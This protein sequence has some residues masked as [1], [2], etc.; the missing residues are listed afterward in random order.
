MTLVE[1][2]VNHLK[3]NKGVQDVTAARY[4]H[5]LLITAKFIH[6]EEGRRDY[7]TGGKRVRSSLTQESVG[8]DTTH[9]KESIICDQTFLATVSRACSKPSLQVRRK[10]RCRQSASAYEFH[11][12]ASVCCE[13]WPSQRTQNSS[14]AKGRS[15]RET[16]SKRLVRLLPQGDNV[17]AFSSDGTVWLIETGYKTVSKYGPN[18]VRFDTAEYQL[19][20]YHLGQYNRISRPRLLSSVDAHEYFFVNKRGTEFKTS[21]S[22]FK[23]SV[24]TL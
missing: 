10:F 19:V 11:N 16:K 13:S 24:A 5:A 1:R 6:V 8:K 22:F 7:E 2:F 12:A 21:G 17:I 23:I 20:A 9:H 3:Q 18:V 4:V 14:R 15:R